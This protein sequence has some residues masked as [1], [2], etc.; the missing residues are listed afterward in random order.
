MGDKSRREMNYNYRALLPHAD[1]TY[2]TFYIIDFK[3]PFLALLTHCC[4]IGKSLFTALLF[5]YFIRLH[6]F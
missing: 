6:I 2:R 5:H 4:V 3:Q 1:L